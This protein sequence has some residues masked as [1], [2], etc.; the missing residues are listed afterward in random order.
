MQSKTESASLGLRF[1]RQGIVAVRVQAEGDRWGRM[2]GARFAESE[3]SG[4]LALAGE[5]LPGGLGVE[6]GY[7]RG[8]ASEFLREVCHLPEGQGLGAGAIDQ[9]SS[10][11]LA[12]WVLNTPPMLGAEY[13]TASSLVAVWDRLFEFTRSQ[14]ERLGSVAEFL[15]EYA[16]QWVRVGRVTL[17]L[18]E[19]KADVEF[20]FAFMATYAAGLN[21][22]GRVRRLPLGG[23]LEEFEDRRGKT[24]PLTRAAFV[25]RAAR[26]RSGILRG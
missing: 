24:A 7:W 22:D 17:H 25:S 13:V 16:P 11:Q 4:L 21:R 26:R 10:A 5:V 6:I 3:G 1:L 14:V 2:V 12:E 19:N 20:P 9:P 15:K 8:V 23:A 18:G